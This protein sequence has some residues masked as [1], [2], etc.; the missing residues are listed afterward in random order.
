[1]EPWKPGETGPSSIPW[2]PVALQSHPDRHCSSPTSR[3]R[4]YK[5]FWISYKNIEP[6]EPPPG[7]LNS[8]RTSPSAPS[9]KRTQEFRRGGGQYLPPVCKAAIPAPETK[10]RSPFATAVGYFMSGRADSGVQPP[11]LGN[12]AD[13]LSAFQQELLLSSPAFARYGGNQLESKGKKVF[14]FSLR[15]PQPP[16]DDYRLN[17]KACEA[18]LTFVCLTLLF[19]SAPLSTFS[20]QFEVCGNLVER[21]G[22]GAHGGIWGRRT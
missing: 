7:T 22:N 3:S 10:V 17:Q 12:R 6:P 1:M 14:L 2:K 19:F 21:D 20:S 15:Q 18:Q 5:L 9:L 16:G 8:Q 4:C 11:L 13:S